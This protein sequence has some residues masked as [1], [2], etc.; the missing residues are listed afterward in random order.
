LQLQAT[1]TG[2]KPL[3]LHI[4]DGSTSHSNSSSPV[5]SPHQN[6]QAFSPL[7]SPA[8]RRSGTDEVQL[9]A[10]SLVGMMS[11][12]SAEQAL[13]I[14]E[15]DETTMQQQVVKCYLAVKLEWKNDNEIT[16]LRE[17]GETKSF[18]LSD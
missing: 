18:K 2:Q 10:P 17:N 6:N 1:P 3:T 14:V 13:R 7:S 9:L 11:D 12:S 4:P 5:N 8:L 16:L 15:D